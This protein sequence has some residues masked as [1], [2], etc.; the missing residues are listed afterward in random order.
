[1]L[2]LLFSFPGDCSDEQ[3]KSLE[4]FRAQVDDPRFDDVYLLRFLRAR[5]FDL[6]ETNKMWM[7]FI[8]WRNKNEIDNIKVVLQ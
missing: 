7:E 4:I 8:K 2:I 3:L 6:Q 5:K 1:M